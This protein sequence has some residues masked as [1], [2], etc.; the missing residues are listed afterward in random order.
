MDGPGLPALLTRGIDEIPGAAVLLFDHELRYVL[1][2]GRALRDNGVIAEEYEGRPASECLPPHRWA[3]LEPLYRSALAG[4]AAVTEV[5]GLLP[6]RHYIVRTAPVR[7][8][9]G[10]IIGGAS[11]AT[12]VT[13]LRRVQEARTAGERRLRLTFESSPIGMALESLDGWFL[14]VNPALCQMVGRTSD[15]LLSHRVADVL[16]PDETGPDLVTRDQVASGLVDSLAAERRLRR[17]DGSRAWALHAIGLL[18]DDRGAAQ[19]FVSHYVDITEARGARE[20]MRHLATHDGLTGLLN[21]EGFWTSVAPI[22]GHPARAG[23]GLAVLFI[24]L[25][26]FKAVNDTL[27]HA[28]GD[29]VLAEIG[30]RI[31]AALRADDLVARFGGDEFVAL[32]TAVRAPADA[33]VVAD[34]LHRCVTRPIGVAGREVHVTLSIGLTLV[35]PDDLAEAAL[36]RA[37]LSM[38]RAKAAGG[39]RTVLAD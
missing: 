35:R 17:A 30:G 37:D 32:L 1:V 38:Y 6:G 39:G 33:A 21:R 13:E 29:Q 5:E 12:D 10:T 27:G 16:D 22:V 20:R 2:R 8:A 36:K 4:H 11:V 18:T 3:A 7:D 26:D 24:D 19:H 15:W 25:D 23:T 28:V 9:G 31:G 34:Q 14:E